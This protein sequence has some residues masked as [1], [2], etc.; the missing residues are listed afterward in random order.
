MVERA[1]DALIL[2]DPDGRIVMVNQLACATLGYT[3]LE[4]TGCH[5][6]MV[7]DGFDFSE[8]YPLWQELS[9]D[10]PVTREYLH[11]RKDGTTFPV[12]VRL[13]AF[14]MA[15]RRLIL[16]LARDISERKAYQARLEQQANYDLLTGL[17]N[18]MLFLDRLQTALAAARRNSRLLALLFIDLDGFKN[19]N[20]MLGH[21]AG[22]A[23][24]VESGRRI[25][26]TL[27]EADTVARF[28]G[29]EF[30][31]L[32]AEMESP[33]DGELVAAKIRESFRAAFDIA[34]RPVAIRASIG[35]ALFPDDAED[36]DTLIGQA[37][38]RMY[39][40]K[41]MARM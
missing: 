12:E 15:G 34:G 29:D 19:I 7:I 41:E 14:D 26:G 10:H 6:G 9:V 2:H 37:D 18:R 25:A 13:S 5:V 27:R 22:D 38:T 40:A 11:R 32:L 33:R 8:P 23:L 28:G 1:S 21:P 24:L 31:V 39:Q 36:A 35:V 4:L 30:V 16:A 3:C 17:P 20:D